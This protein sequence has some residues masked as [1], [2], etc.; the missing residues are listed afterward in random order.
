MLDHEWFCGR[1]QREISTLAAV[2]G[3]APDVALDV[4]NC[5]GWTVA[6]LAQHTGA[7]HRWATTIVET[8]AGGR[9][10]FPAADSPW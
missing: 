8:R 2:V 9:V 10:P 1:T 5:P 6:H 7:I 3:D 4:P